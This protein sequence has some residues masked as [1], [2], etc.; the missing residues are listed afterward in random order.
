MKRILIIIAVMLVSFVCSAQEKKPYYLVV[1]KDTVGVVFT[2]AD[3][4]KLDND[5][6]ILKLYERLVASY[7]KSGIQYIKIVDKMDKEI[8]VLNLKIDEYK[9]A[10]ADKDVVIAD[11]KQI[12]HNK[13]LSD[14]AYEQQ[15]A[16]DKVIIQNLNKQ[17]NR[18]FWQKVGG[19]AIALIVIGFLVVK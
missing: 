5:G 7:D 1:E 10:I 14:A 9:K 15:L 19:G 3:A 8:G 6:D 12:I 17:V 16:N 4:Q 2:V 18:S 13:A 11:L